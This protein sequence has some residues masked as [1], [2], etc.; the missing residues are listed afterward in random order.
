MRISSRLNLHRAEHGDR[1][2]YFQEGIRFL[3]NAGFDAADMSLNFMQKTDIPWQPVIEAAIMA[4]DQENLPIEICHLPYSTT[5]CKHPEELPAFQE[6]FHL[7]LEAAAV[8]KPK[9]AVMHANTTTTPLA[10]FNRAKMYD[11]VMNHLSPFVEHAQ[12]CGV[13]VLL[14]NMV[15]RGR[16]TDLYRYCAQPDELCEIADQLGVDICWD[17]G[18]AHAAGLRQSEALAYLGSR[19]KAL[20]VNDNRGNG[21]DDHLPPFLGKIDWQDAMAGLKAIGY[22]GLFNYEVKADAVPQSLRASFVNYLMETGK[23]LTGW[24]EKV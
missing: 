24:I 4:A 1:I 6:A 8:L 18:H 17:F 16:G 14:E 13:T 11:S 3:K 22:D 10:D 7:A 5:I 9:Y 19:V 23:L 2:E 12:R 20:H 21:G 15:P